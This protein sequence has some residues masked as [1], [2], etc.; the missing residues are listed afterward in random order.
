MTAPTPVA[1]QVLKDIRP[2]CDRQY[3]AKVC[4]DIVSWLS[5]TEYDINTDPDKHDREGLL[6]RISIFALHDQSRLHV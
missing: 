1:A 4:Q 6:Q 3:Q 5:G 2:L